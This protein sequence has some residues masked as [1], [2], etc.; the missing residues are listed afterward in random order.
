[1]LRRL[2]TLVGF[3]ACGSVV[4]AEPPAGRVLSKANV[5]A[6]A[7]DTTV[8]SCKTASGLLLPVPGLGFVP[9]PVEVWDCTVIHTPPN[10]PAGAPK[11]RNV[12]RLFTLV[13]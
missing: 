10:A 1:M 6:G 11:L 12:V 9:L 4:L 7:C 3:L 5:P 13:E 2:L 8:I